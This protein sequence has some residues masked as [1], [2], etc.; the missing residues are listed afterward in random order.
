MKMRTSLA[1]A[2][3]LMALAAGGIAG[4]GDD[5]G[6]AVKSAPTAVPKGW[7]ADK[8]PARLEDEGERLE[9]AGYTTSSPKGGS[10]TP[11]VRVG[12][13][14]GGSAY[15][16]VKTKETGAKQ[17]AQANRQYKGRLRAELVGG[18]VYIASSGKNL[19]EGRKKLTRAQLAEFEEIVA[20]GTGRS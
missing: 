9:E 7:V 3:V 15:V 1:C 2:S 14:A 8:V 17:I 6:A 19:F 13:R 4:C 16:L 18:N 20:L 5:D 10:A 11:I 12:M